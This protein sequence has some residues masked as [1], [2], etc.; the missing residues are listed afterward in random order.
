MVPSNLSLPS[1]W[2]VASSS[3]RFVGSGV[4]PLLGI[5]EPLASHSLGRWKGET[6]LEVR[7]GWKGTQRPKQSQ[8][9]GVGAA[10]M[11]ARWSE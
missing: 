1:E 9:K 6:C 7:V 5:P 4:T 3:D 10:G 2:G 8:G 11:I